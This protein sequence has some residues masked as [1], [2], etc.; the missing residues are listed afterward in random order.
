MHLVFDWYF[1]PYC[2]L[3][4]HGYK[5]AVSLCDEIAVLEINKIVPQNTLQCKSACFRRWFA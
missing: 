4:L 1:L 3:R 2:Q 5:I